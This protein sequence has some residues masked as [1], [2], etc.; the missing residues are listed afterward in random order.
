MRALAFQ[1]TISNGFW[2]LNIIS[3]IQK[4]TEELFC[5]QKS[6]IIENSF[7]ISCFWNLLAEKQV[8][9]QY[10]RNGWRHFFTQNNTSIV[11]SAWRK[12]QRLGVCFF[13][14][15]KMMIILAIGY[16][17]ICCT[18]PN[19]WQKYNNWEILHRCIFS[20]KSWNSCIWSEII[21]QPDRIPLNVLFV[22][23]A[24]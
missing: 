2:L 13:V 6:I 23:H 10:R 22:Y 18:S 5:N 9:F 3:W 14:A 17:T 8:L 1:S 16:I 11:H 20:F 12:K 21:M 24:L 19:Y 7:G 15:Q 4:Y